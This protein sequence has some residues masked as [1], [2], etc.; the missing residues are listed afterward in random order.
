MDVSENRGTPKS[1]I[2]I[3][4]SFINH[5]FWG[6]PIFG[7]AHIILIQISLGWIKG[8][9]LYD[10]N[11]DF[12]MRKK[13]NFHAPKKIATQRVDVLFTK[14]VMTGSLGKL[15]CNNLSVKNGQ[16]A[17]RKHLFICLVLQ[18]LVGIVSLKMSWIFSK[19]WPKGP[20]NK[21]LNSLTFLLNM[22]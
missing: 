18:A 16:V 5:S 2:L 11:Y 15:D 22:Y 8:V 20:L 4:F 1:S 17:L 7:N 21:S 19:T 14:C 9:W 6:A 10:Y 3:G 12:W 13:S